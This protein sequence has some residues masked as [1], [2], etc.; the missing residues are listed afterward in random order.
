MKCLMG[1]VAAVV[2]PGMITLPRVV[3]IDFLAGGAQG[4]A[5]VQSD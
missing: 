3:L 1:A 2:F 5:P 4:L